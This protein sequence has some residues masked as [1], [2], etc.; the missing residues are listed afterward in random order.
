M[1]LQTNLP[2]KSIESIQFVASLDGDSGWYIYLNSGW[3]FDPMANDGTRFIPLES[4]SE[5]NSLSVYKVGA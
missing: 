1:T 5:A 2:A 4:E 3:S